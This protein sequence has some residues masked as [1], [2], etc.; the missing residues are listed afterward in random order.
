MVFKVKATAQIQILCMAKLAKVD[1]QMA[2]AIAIGS[3]YH[4]EKK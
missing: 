2:I 3:K 1:G 4:V